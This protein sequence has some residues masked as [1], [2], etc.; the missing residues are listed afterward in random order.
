MSFESFLGTWRLVSFEVRTKEGQVS[1]PYGK[2]AAGYILYNEDGYMSVHIM[3]VGRRRFTAGDIMGGTADEK[4]SAAET[5]IAYC[6][7][8]VVE[9]DKVVH[10]I[11]VSFFPN[12]IGVRQERFYEFDGDRLT[13]STLPLLV[14]GVKQTG[15]VVWER[16]KSK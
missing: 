7:R 16:V 11:E 3:P 8:F 13:L 5:Y 9:G 6:G 12:W 10:H 1:Y 2:D 4:V 14:G 15:H